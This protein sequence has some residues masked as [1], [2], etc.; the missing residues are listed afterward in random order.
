MPQ[1]LWAMINVRQN[2][3]ENKI[4]IDLQEPFIF[5]HLLIFDAQGNPHPSRSPLRCNKNKNGILKN[6]I[7]VKLTIFIHTTHRF[8]III[9]Y[10]NLMIFI[11]SIF[12]YWMVKITKTWSHLKWF[13]I[14]QFLLGLEMYNIVK[15]VH[16]ITFIPYNQA[17]I[18]K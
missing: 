8:I 3:Q 17:I 13:L 9:I 2:S 15:N 5:A 10:F 1:T 11:H 18:Y 16:T 14:W 6:S 7:I 4:Q 12:E